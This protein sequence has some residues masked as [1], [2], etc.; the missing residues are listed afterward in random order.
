MACSVTS[1]QGLPANS[2]RGIALL[3]LDDDPEADAK[4]VF[5]GLEG[6]DR[7]KVLS[8]FGHWQ[9]GQVRDEYHHGFDHSPNE[10]CYVFKWNKGNIRHRMYG[11]LCHP[12]SADGRF[13]GCVLVS[14][15]TKNERK[16]IPPNWQG[17]TD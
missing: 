3:D 16:P 11:F 8:R 17:S 1:I 10:L 13:L 7:Y 5:E 6:N 2:R 15:T 14:H 4:A 12:K 9:D